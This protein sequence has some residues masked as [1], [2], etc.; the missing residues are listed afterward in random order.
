MRDESYS[1]IWQPK[2]LIKTFFG[3]AKLF[4]GE[5]KFSSG[6]AEFIAEFILVEFKSMMAKSLMAL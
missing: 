3:A 4:I 1:F 6:E 5:V 2:V